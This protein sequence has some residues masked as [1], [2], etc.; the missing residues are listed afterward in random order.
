MKIFNKLFMDGDWNIAYRTKANNAQFNYEQKFVP[1]PYSKDYWFAD[2]M[3]FEFNGKSYLF[4]E[5]FDRK[6][7]IGRIG[8]FEIINGIPQ[9]FKI[10]LSENYH[11]SYPCVFIG[12]S[13]KAYMV[14]ES[15]ENLSLD[16]YESVKFP[17]E[18]KKVKTFISGVNFAD[19]TVFK[20][21]NEYWLYTYEAKP[22]CYTCYLYK[23]NLEELSI[24]LHS[25]KNYM[26]NCCRS[27]GYIINGDNYLICP[28]QDCS[29]IYGKE[30]IFNELSITSNDFNLKEIFRIDNDRINLVDTKNAGGGGRQATYLFCHCK[31]GVC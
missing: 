19:T 7:Y 13:G 4:C 17:N 9:N 27:G 29:K 10:V 6:E 20:F 30:L 31:Y 3:G 22:E 21:E 24:T 5:A 14:P 2:P 25:S 15:G 8:V 26:T 18:W 23:L 11:L 16:L 1:L 28:I 12:N